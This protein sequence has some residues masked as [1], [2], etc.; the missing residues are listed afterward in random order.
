MSK[1]APKKRRPKRTREQ[2]PDRTQPPGAWVN[3]KD[4]SPVKPTHS[5]KI[6]LE[7]KTLE[8][9]FRKAHGFQKKD[10]TEQALLAFI[11]NYDPDTQLTYKLEEYGIISKTR[12]PI[13]D[14][15][16]KKRQPKR[17]QEQLPDRTQPPGAWVNRKDYSPAKPTH[18]TKIEPEIKTLEED[19]RKA[20]GFQ[21]KDL[22]EQ[23]L[24]AFID[25]YDPDTQPTYTL[26]EG[27]IISEIRQ[28]TIDI[29]G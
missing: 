20:H 12:H 28:R 14:N 27:N 13:N 6:E 19:F 9:D 8:E 17:T 11:D 22:T 26:E 23:A 18:S 24:L 16:P 2:L 4:Y 15:P 3:R 25:N 1:A 29:D 10:L 5:T 7:I 21:K